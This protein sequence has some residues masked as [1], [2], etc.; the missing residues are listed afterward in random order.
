MPR[1][2]HIIFHLILSYLIKDMWPTHGLHMFLQTQ[3]QS[4]M[5]PGFRVSRIVYKA[6]QNMCFGINIAFP[7]HWQ[8][9][10]WVFKLVLTVIKL[11]S[12]SNSFHWRKMKTWNKVSQHY[13]KRWLTWKRPTLGT[14]WVCSL[15]PRTSS[16][17]SKDQLEQDL[18]CKVAGSPTSGYG[19]KSGQ[20]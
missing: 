13:P 2:C 18:W 9:V 4:N 14:L 11:W 19:H 16:Q 10:T 3:A 7:P 15:L 8:R 1:L 17:E 20:V 5:W 6:C 12:S